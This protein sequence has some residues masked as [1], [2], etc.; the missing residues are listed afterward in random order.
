MPL[1]PTTLAQRICTALGLDPNKVTSL[2]LHFGPNG[3]PQAT[4]VT[5]IRGDVENPLLEQIEGCYLLEK[6]ALDDPERA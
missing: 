5:A 2:T 3:L 1:E 4:I 6:T